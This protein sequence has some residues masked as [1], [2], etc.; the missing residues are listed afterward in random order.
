MKVILWMLDRPIRGLIESILNEADYDVSLAND[1]TM[2]QEDRTLK[3]WGLLILEMEVMIHDTHSIIPFLERLRRLGSC[4]VLILS[5]PEYSPLIRKN[6]L[7]I[8]HLVDHILRFP[9]D[10]YELLDNVKRYL[11]HNQ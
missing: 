3:N 4:R 7:K 5:K 6:E 10:K 11:K 9:L 8:D 2:T 1:Q